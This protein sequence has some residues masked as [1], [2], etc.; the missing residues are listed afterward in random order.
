MI[1]W[2]LIL[3]YRLFIFVPMQEQLKPLQAQLKRVKD[4]PAPEFGSLQSWERLNLGAFTHGDSCA[5]DASRN[6]QGQYNGT[7]M[8]YLGDTKVRVSCGFM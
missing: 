6:A 1:Q 7:P 2:R 8:P 3:I 5:A 4:L